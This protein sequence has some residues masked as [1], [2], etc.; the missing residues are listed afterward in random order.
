MADGLAEPGL[1]ATRVNGFHII[2]VVIPRPWRVRAIALAVLA[3]LTS[4]A[5][6]NPNSITTGPLLAKD[7]TLRVVLDDQPQT[8]DPGQ[9]QYPYETAVLRTIA[10]PLLKPLADLSGVSPAAAE[11]YETQHDGTVYVFH[12]RR[13]A[14]YNDGQPVKAQDFVYAWQ[15][16][17]DPRQAAPTETFFAAAVFN[18]AQVAVLDPQR[19]KDRIDPALGTLGL[20][21]LDDLTFQVTLARS[22]PAFIWIA[23][24]PAGAPI[25]AD[26]VG[27]YGDRAWAAKPESLI[28]NGPFMVGAMTANTSVKVV[29]NP[30]Y[31]GGRPVLTAI[32]FEIVND[33]A[34]A[35]ARYKSGRLDEMGVQPAQATQVAGSASLLKELVKTPAL[36]VYWMAFRLSSP[37]LDNARL[38]QAIAEAIDREA[39][40]AQVFQGQAMPAETFIPKGMLGYTPGLGTTQHFDVVQARA[41]LAASGL[42]ASQLMGIKLSYDQTSDFAKATA[43]FVRDQVKTNL[44]VEITLDGVDTNTMSS[45]L[46]S[47]DFQIAGPVGWTAD[48][49]DYSDWYPIFLSTNSNNF[50]LYHNTQYDHFVNAAATDIQAG[51]RGQEY[52]QAQQLLVGDAP[53][54]FLAQST[55]WN[56]VRSYVRGVTTSAVDDWP[57][58]LFPAQIYIAQH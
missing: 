39:F 44:G 54:A 17:I 13:T 19:D 18:G 48:Y 15:R 47:G 11:S 22:D 27:R 30:H 9:T 52:Q 23:A 45:R 7:Q 3:L 12:L 40:V 31:W 8:L 4:A 55:S 46:G 29:R 38:R 5:T 28:T 51:R 35:L 49:P 25:R 53:V 14:Q 33:G 34:A 50:D 32:D 10:E 26:V 24:M 21:A 1:P 20:K 57:G 58:E 2:P 6:C 37:P 16:L 56:L 43:A 36:T 41:S 42:S